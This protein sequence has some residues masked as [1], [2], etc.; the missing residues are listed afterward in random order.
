[1]ARGGEV[2]GQTVSVKIFACKL[3]LSYNCICLFVYVREVKSIII[4][5][6]RKTK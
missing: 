3:K 6:S 2:E 4:V 1:M 5:I